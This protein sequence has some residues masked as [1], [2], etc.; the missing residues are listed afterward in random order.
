MCL[1]VPKIQASRTIL[2]RGK[3]TPSMLLPP[4]TPGAT[5]RIMLVLYHDL[6]G[7]QT[8]KQSIGAEKF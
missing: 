4:L 7:V 8:P 1:V 6:A 2:M 5:G 3:I